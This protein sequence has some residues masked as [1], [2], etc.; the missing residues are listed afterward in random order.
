MGQ[1]QKSL[2]AKPLFTIHQPSVKASTT[3]SPRV[4]W[5]SD[6]KWWYP[7]GKDGDASNKNS[8]RL[9][10]PIFQQDIESFLNPEEGRSPWASHGEKPPT[11][12]KE[13]R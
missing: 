5:E 8:R 12:Q 4:G 9:H 13:A 3:P 7:C 10:F 1:I 11:S 2:V 6:E